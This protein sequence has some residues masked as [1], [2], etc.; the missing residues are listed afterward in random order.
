MNKP[1]FYIFAP[2]FLL[3]VYI[4]NAAAQYNTVNVCYKLVSGELRK[5]RHLLIA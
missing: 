2:A 3:T 4:G 5:D 1:I